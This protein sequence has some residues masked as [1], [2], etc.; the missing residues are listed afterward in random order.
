MAREKLPCIGGKG[1]V[2]GNVIRGRGRGSANVYINQTRC[3][4]QDQDSVPQPQPHNEWPLL[5]PL[6]LVI[7]QKPQS[8]FCGGVGVA[9]PATEDRSRRPRQTP[10]EENVV[11]I[12]LEIESSREQGNTVPTGHP[13]QISRC[14]Q[15]VRNDVEAEAGDVLVSAIGEYCGIAQANTVTA[16]IGIENYDDYK[17]SS[18]L[19]HDDD[20]QYSRLLEIDENCP[21]PLADFN[22]DFDFDFEEFN[23]Y[24]DI[25]PLPFPWLSRPGQ[26]LYLLNS[27]YLIWQIL[28]NCTRIYTIP[29]VPCDYFW[30]P[31]NS[32]HDSGWSAW[33]E[34]N[35][36]KCEDL[37]KYCRLS[38]RDNSKKNETDC[39]DIPNY[40]PPGGETKRPHVNRGDRPSM[41][42]VVQM[43]EGDG[44]TLAMPLNSFSTTNQSITRG[45][46]GG[47]PFS[48]MLEIIS[49]SD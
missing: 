17:V 28:L 18:G 37:G 5:L 44:K 45:N 6:S 36:T 19:N 34:P 10:G 12:G 42:T 30:P 49:E 39:F 31:S 3:A 43:L 2:S 47:R 7:P 40:T 35:C 20:G 32:V 11:P 4:H 8:H 48:S 27:G 26:N 21:S 38:S 1:R 33:S 24:D 16:E 9:S 25:A 15:P 46:M 29:S 22:F 23:Y 14:Q 41:K 13:L